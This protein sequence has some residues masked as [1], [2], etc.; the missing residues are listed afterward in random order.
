MKSNPTGIYKE[1]KDRLKREEKVL[2]IGLPCQVAALRNYIS[3]D[4]SDK[5]YTID[6]IC[7]GTPSPKVLDIFLK[8]YGLTLSSLKDINSE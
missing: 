7:H 4:L 3:T 6:L 8:Q 5:L 2:F 1:I